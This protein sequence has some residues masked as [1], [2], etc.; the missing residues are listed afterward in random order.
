MAQALSRRADM[1]EQNIHEKHNLSEE[2]R[3]L[4]HFAAR[5]FSTECPL[6][7]VKESIEADQPYSREL[8]MKMAEQ[9]Y[10]GLLLPERS[11]G[12]ALGLIEL[13]IISEEMGKACLPGPFISN[14]WGSCAIE[15]A[16]TATQRGG[17]LAEI[18][19]GATTL[20]VALLQ[21]KGEETPASAE[22]NARM[23]GDGYL[24]NGESIHVMDGEHADHVLMTAKNPGRQSV[25]AVIPLDSPGFTLTR[26]PGLDHMRPCYLVSCSN[27]P[28]A[29]EQLLAVGN[30]ADSAMAYATSVATLA[31]TA[32]M[33][34]TIQ[35][36]LEAVMKF[37]GIRVQM[38]QVI[39]AFKDISSRC[40]D[41]IAAV[42]NCRSAVYSAATALE[43]GEAGAVDAVSLARTLTAE[44]SDELGSLLLQR[45]EGMGLTWEHD[46]HLFR[47]APP[48]FNS[49]S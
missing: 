42:E 19:K 32:E 28:V 22:L 14:L 9:G 13:A 30:S 10:L 47:G 31:A 27:V 21:Q 15:R 12:L 43:Q 25:L 18:V 7:K 34:G 38:G 17:I 3:I 39:E 29:K 33:V 44:T 1:A 49:I 23:N 20:T 35:W 24:F 40:A 46:I 36:I 5:F 6:G 2:Q 4:K 37:T 41:L 16:S 45:Q 11:G 8:W 48:F 26:V